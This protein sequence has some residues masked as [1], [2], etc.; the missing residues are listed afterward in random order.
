MLTPKPFI[1]VAMCYHPDFLLRS[2]SFCILSQK[3]QVLEGVLIPVA[4][5]SFIAHG[6]V[7]K[8]G[9]KRPGWVLLASLP[10]FLHPSPFED[11]LSA[12]RCYT[13]NLHDFQLF[14][15]TWS[16]PVALV[17]KEL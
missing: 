1:F 15:R 12:S 11:R 5:N 16:N 7:Y 9:I 3:T 4:L 2:Y 8:P 13:F 17:P 6:A 14:P 10:P